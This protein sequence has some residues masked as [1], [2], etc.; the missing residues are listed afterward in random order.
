MPVLV[1]T[2]SGSNNNV[3][4]LNYGVK[5]GAAVEISKKKNAKE[6]AA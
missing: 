4:G 3:N 6:K 2:Y 1:H 5:L